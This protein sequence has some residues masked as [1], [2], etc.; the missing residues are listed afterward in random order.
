MALKRKKS[1]KVRRESKKYRLLKGLRT[2]LKAIPSSLSLN[3]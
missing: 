1:R 2:V 3:L